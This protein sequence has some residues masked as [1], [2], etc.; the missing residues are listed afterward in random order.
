MF[1]SNNITDAQEIADAKKKV[2]TAK[3]AVLTR[4]EFCFYGTILAK[5]DFL[6]DNAIGTAAV[7][8]KHMI[9]APKFINSLPHRQVVFTVMHEIKHIVYR[10][11]DR[12]K[13]RDP[14]LWNV[15]GDYVI[16]NFL[17]HKG[18]DL[19][20]GVLLDHKYD[21][22]STDDIYFALLEE[23]KND[24]SF[25]PQPDHNDLLPPNSLDPTSSGKGGNANQK[26]VDDFVEQAIGEAMLQVE[27][28]ERRGI[29]SAGNVPA[30]IKRYYEELMRPSVPWQTVLSRFLFGVS[31]TDYSFRRPSRRGMA[32]DLTLPGRY[33]NSMDCIDFAIDTSGSVSQKTFS[34]FIS[35]IHE[36]F[37]QFNPEN[38]GIMQ[39]DDVIKDIRKVCSLEEFKTIE[40]KGGGGTTIQPVLKEY[41]KNDA[42][43]LVI[44]T[45][46]YF[47]H[48]KQDDPNKPVIWAIY[49]N[50]HF[51]PAFGSAVHFKLD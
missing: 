45:D 43:A 51:V 35:E 11:I 40:F 3:V 19:I 7:D 42:K 4:P 16:N 49:D 31:K 24:P 18:F 22:M 6:Y 12:L 29:K 25:N 41:A 26:A 46:G 2:S 10:H 38:I 30:D 32:M 21:G 9:F 17:D 13:D 5:L 20:P 50:P 8:G 27:M 44:L 28:N 1:M 39:F 37:K 36:V 47:S 48:S 15:A 23:K 34:K 14:Q 33:G